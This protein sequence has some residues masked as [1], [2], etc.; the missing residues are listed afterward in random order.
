MTALGRFSARI[1]VSSW[2]VATCMSSAAFA[3]PVTYKNIHVLDGAANTFVI[4]RDNRIY[5]VQDTD[6]ALWSVNMDGSDFKKLEN[7][8]GLVTTKGTVNF[9]MSRTGIFYK[10]AF[11]KTVSGGISASCP[12]THYTEGD[13]PVPY[14]VF[15]YFFKFSD[16]TPAESIPVSTSKPICPTGV[17]SVD[18]SDNLYFV[19]EINSVVS[20]ANQSAVGARIYRLAADGSTLTEIYKFSAEAMPS[21]TSPRLIMSGQDGDWLYGI[22]SGGGPGTGYLYRIKADGTGWQVLAQFGRDTG[23]TRQVAYPSLIEVGDYLYGALRWY[24]PGAGGN[25]N[26]TLYRIKKDGTEPLRVLHAFNRDDG[27]QPQDQMAL[28]GDGKVYGSTRSGG[29]QNQGSI[30]SIDPT[31]ITEAESGV[32]TNLFDFTGTEADSELPTGLVAARSGKLYGL[33]SFSR[34]FELDIGYTPPH[35]VI[36]SFVSTPSEVSWQAGTT[37]PKVT[38]AWS[39]E[40]PTGF[41]TCTANS[42]PEGAWSGTKNLSGNEEVSVQQEGDNTYTLTCDNGSGLEN[43]TSTQSVIVKAVAAPPP[44]L[45]NTFSVTPSLAEPRATVRFGWSTQDAVS[46]RAS[47]T[48][49]NLPTDQLSSGWEDHTL[50]GSEGEKTF[51][52]TCTGR[53]GDTVTDE[54]TVTVKIGA[55]GNGGESSSIEVS[56]SGGPVMPWLLLPLSLLALCRRPRQRLH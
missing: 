43:G 30:Y 1:L 49:N 36:T 56:D 17:M 19:S 44:P 11:P 41:T 16:G 50:A 8:N 32:E 14:N 29:S 34:L 42:I 31:A 28:G 2:C 3:A 23:D 21:G 22:N 38:L 27:Q 52:L 45:I 25:G 55:S 18:A 10:G 46:C 39:V 24:T 9:V 4:G 5:G 12:A 15:G 35:P 54:V 33:A 48:G 53:G 13:N 37:Q 47:W 20:E 7:P 40:D 6:S 51:T 26:G